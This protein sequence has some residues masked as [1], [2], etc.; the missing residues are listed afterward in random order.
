MLRKNLLIALLPLCGAPAFADTGA[1]LQVGTTGYGFD[2]GQQL[3]NRIGARVGYSALNYSRSFHTSDVDYDGKLKLSNL[4]ALADLE[5]GY[6]FRISGGVVFGNNKVDVNGKA[7][8]GSYTI[9]GNTYAASN[10]GSFTGRIKLGNGAAPYL[11]LGY[12]MIG[13]KGFGFYAD[14]GAM[15]A[16]KPSTTLDITCGSALSAAQC[17]QLRTDADAER[18]KVQDKADGFKWYPVVNIGLSYAF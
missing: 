16:G 9:N 3:T 14:L 17:T 4:R 2:V 13:K 6:G 7:S 11:G 18:Q 10:I 1:G 15:Y 8:G 12:G 5:L